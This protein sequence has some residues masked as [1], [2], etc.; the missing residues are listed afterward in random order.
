VTPA[1][2]A[3]LIAETAK[4]LPD[5]MRKAAMTSGVRV[6]A[7]LVDRAPTGVAGVLKAAWAANPKQ[8]FGS[9]G[10][11]KVVS[12]TNSA[13][14]AGI[15]E[16]GARPHPVSDEGRR[17]IKQWVIRKGI[18]A[19]AALDPEFAGRDESDIAAIITDGICRKLLMV[20]QKGRFDVL[21]LLEPAA[22]WTRA[23]FERELDR[24][25]KAG[26]R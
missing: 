16:R 11:G 21:K 6:T 26:K 18:A 15:I 19:R 3:K 17:S 5:A 10:K 20:G 8:H 4:K 12:V 13:P 14:Y 22:A 23:E 2:V 7:E 24:L 1:E 9:N 25:I